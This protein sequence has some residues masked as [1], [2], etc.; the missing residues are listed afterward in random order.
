MQMN[1]L[2]PDVSQRR[3]GILMVLFSATCWGLSGTASQ[4]LF[5]SDHVQVAWLV[6]IRML[7]SGFVLVTWGLL[8]PGSATRAVFRQPKTWLSLL[9]FAVVGLLSV[10]Y[11]YFKAIADGNAASGTLLQYLGPP[12]IVLF[13]A[14][15]SRRWPSRSAWVAMVFALAGNLLLVTGG[16]FRRLDV[17]IPAVIWGVASAASLAFYTLFPARLMRTFDTI[18]VVGW[19]MLMGGLISAGIGRPWDLFPARWS[20]PAGLLVAFVVL[21]GTLAAFSLYL[22]SQR[23]LPASDAGLFA[24]AEPVAAVLAS[25]LF[26]HLHMNLIALGGAGLTLVG[27]VQLSRTSETAP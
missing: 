2:I 23:F 1:I 15:T 5:Q 13:S 18:S 24:T 14:A 27:I 21:L 9:V 11:T 16:H 10:Q 26:L 3:R 7:C 12:M 19:G 6:S 4:V 17:P 22:A 8:T 25:L 20:V